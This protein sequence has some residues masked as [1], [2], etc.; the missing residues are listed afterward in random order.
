MGIIVFQYTL[1]VLLIIG[2]A[3][4]IYLINDNEE[5]VRDDYYGITYTLLRF[6]DNDEATTE[7]TKRILK[8]VSECVNFV[9]D[10]FKDEDNLEKEQKAL[11]LAR[12]GIE[13][14][15]FSSTIDDESLICIIRLATALIKPVNQ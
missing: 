15:Q 13:E 12:E 9:E 14:L 3:Y 6:L 1:V 10:N 4:F 8:I 5:N 11:S 2:I 7:N